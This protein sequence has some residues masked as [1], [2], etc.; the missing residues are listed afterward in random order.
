[1][2]SILHYADSNAQKHYRAQFLE[3]DPGLEI[4]GVF[5]WFILPTYTNSL[6]T[7]LLPREFCQ[8]T[9][10]TIPEELIYHFFVQIMEALYF[11]DKVCNPAIDHD[12]LRL[13]IDHGDVH[14]GNI[15]IHISANGPIETFPNLVII[16]LICALVS[17]PETDY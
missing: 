4:S 6:Y 2:K 16:D 9:R 5:D 1:M 17:V 10:L 14:G 15:M 3:Y 11:L 13:P 12:D 7:P 8:D